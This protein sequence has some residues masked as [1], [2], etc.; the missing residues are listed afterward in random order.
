MKALKAAA[1]FFAL[2]LAFTCTLSVYAEGDDA[3]GD[4][5]S[6]G[7]VS[8]VAPNYDYYIKYGYKPLVSYDGT[9][10]SDYITGQT[11][12]TAYLK[13]GENHVVSVNYYRFRDYVFV[14]WRCGNTLYKPGD[15]IY[16]VNSNMTLIAEWAR[17]TRPDMS[18]L[19][20]VSYSQ[21]G[22]VVETRSV[23]L[24]TT[25]VL[26]DGLWLDNCGRIFEGGKSFLL[27]FNTVDFV[28]VDSS[29][30]TVSVSYNGGG[31]SDGIQCGFS[32]AA[33]GSFIV[34]GCYGKR[35]GYKFTGWTDG[36]GRV[37]LAG[38]TCVAQSNTVL[39]A[40][41]QE[42][43]KPVPDYCTVTVSVG[44]GGTATPAGKSTVEKGKSFSFTVAANSGYKLIS[45]SSNGAEL[46]TG[47]EYT[48]AVNSDMSINV[49]FEKLPNAPVGD[50]SSTTTDD[51]SAQVGEESGADSNDSSVS[52]SQTD[53]S[54]NSGGA[55]IY[56]VIVAVIGCALGIGAAAWF[57][58]KSKAKS[59]KRKR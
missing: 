6:G 22:K 18:V 33:G 40:M 59:K 38:D 50:N 28:A 12:A 56:V 17:P 3:S 35:D 19:G 34:D 25:V 31:V 23:Q 30:N 46:G 5:T 11:P 1:L 48:L 15:I 54:K 39:T 51:E 8:N 44:E 10:A 16:N 26:R 53:N 43:A 24:G 49:K 42:S 21:G 2:V 41:W 27:S 20:I 58:A 4:D 9:A 7:D 14:G 32:V 37:Y 55:K 29:T 36:N 52:S 45:V 57:A 13:A 47:G